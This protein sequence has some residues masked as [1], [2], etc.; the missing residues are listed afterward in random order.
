MCAYNFGGKGSNPTKLYHLTCHLVGVLTQVQLL[1]GTALLKF[2]KAK[3]VQNSVR[4]RTTFD[5]DR[6]YLWSG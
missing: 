6:K 1:G 2:G 3:N 4:R 5:F